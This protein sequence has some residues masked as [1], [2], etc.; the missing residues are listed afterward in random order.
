[1]H[2]L[3]NKLKSEDGWSGS[4][5]AWNEDKLALISGQFSSFDSSAKV[6]VLLSFIG[7][8]PR[9]I[10]QVSVALT[11]PLIVSDALCLQCS[12][13]VIRPFP[14]LGI[15]PFLVHN[16]KQWAYRKWWVLHQ[17]VYLQGVQKRTDCVLV[18]I[19]TSSHPRTWPLCSIQVHVCV[20]VDQH[21]TCT[22]N[23]CMFL[24]STHHV[25]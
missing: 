9:T 18:I 24:M 7:M 10:S 22:S 1:M 13:M 12:G 4:N 16:C 3:L 19:T 2:Y 5:L 20:H 6:K 8:T 17:L 15:L 21:S 25:S 11:L 14:F 23:A